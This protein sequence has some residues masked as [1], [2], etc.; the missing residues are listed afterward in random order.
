MAAKS[1]PPSSTQQS[2]PMH[3]SPWLTLLAPVIDLA[4]PPPRPVP[5][6]P[7]GASRLELGVGVGRRFGQPRVWGQ[8]VVHSSVDLVEGEIQAGCQRSF[9]SAEAFEAAAGWHLAAGKRLW[10]ILY[11][12]S[13]ACDMPGGMD[14]AFRNFHLGELSPD[15]PTS[16]CLWVGEDLGLGRDRLCVVEG[17]R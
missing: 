11:D 7:A 5:P 17:H 10:V 15:D 16:P 9:S 8:R 6:Q 2:K 4:D 13:P 14:W 12:H 3:L 1:R